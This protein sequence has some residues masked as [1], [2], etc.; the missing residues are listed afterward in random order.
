MPSDLDGSKL[1]SHTPP[2]PAP[3]FE[4]DLLQ[5]IE[6]LVASLP[7]R[8]VQLRIGRIPGHPDW[9]E[10]YFEVA[11][12]N[13]KAARFAGMAASSDLNLTIGEAE[14][15]FVGFARGGNIVRGASWQDELQWI[16]KAVTAGGFKQVHYLDSGDK[17]IGWTAKLFVN[18]NQL[19][20]RNGR[21]TERFFG[22]ER[23]R[24]VTYEPYL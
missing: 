12:T 4:K 22:S 15:E 17:I 8:A 24:T 16:W 3:G 5:E 10:P 19:V 18:G 20:F 14:R 6:R 7:V 9:P 2:C 1:L 21:R 23:R 11:P 13:P